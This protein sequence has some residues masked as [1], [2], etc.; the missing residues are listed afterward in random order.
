MKN[1]GR[2]VILSGPSGSGKTTLYQKLLASPKFKRVLVRSVS[3]TTRLRRPGE[4]P[5]RDY[6]FL[7]QK[8][9]LSRRKKGYF[10]EWKKVFVNYYGTPERPVLDCLRQGKNVLLAID[11]QGAKTVA[12]KDRQALR[13][14]VKVPSWT[15]LKK[16]LSGRGTEQKKDLQIRLRTARKEMK[17]AKGYDYVIVNDRLNRCYKELE[18]ILQK[19]LLSSCP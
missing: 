7:T 8:E 19:E 4:K 15:E 10:L 1:K 18:G 11:V 12:R 16:R 14:F 17:E 6:L 9:F 5:G 13:I 2:I 3:A